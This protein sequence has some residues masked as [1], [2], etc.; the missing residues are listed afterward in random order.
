MAKGKYHLENQVQCQQRHDP[1]FDE[2]W[3]TPFPARHVRRADAD[4]LGTVAYEIPRALNEL[5]GPR[6]WEEEQLGDPVEGPDDDAPGQHRHDPEVHVHPAAGPGPDPLEPEVRE[7]K[8]R[9]DV[10][11]RDRSAGEIS[12]RVPEHDCA[13]QD[14][15]GH[16]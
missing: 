10:L 13:E 16:E 1:A 11:S 6:R 15:E 12:L 7:V 9:L 2:T 5:S 14:A 4:R 8:R 3:R